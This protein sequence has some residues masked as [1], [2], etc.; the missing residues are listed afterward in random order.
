MKKSI[1]LALLTLAFCIA[2]SADKPA[3]AGRSC[4]AHMLS[5]NALTLG[6][7][8]AERT[9]KALDASGA[10]VAVLARAGQDLSQYKLRYSH[11]GLAYKTPAG[12]RVL[13]KLN[14]CGAGTAHLHLQG[15][16]EFF[17]DDPFRYEA[18]YMLLTPAAE[19]ALHQLLA[20][21]QRRSSMHTRP[22]SMVSYAWGTRYQQSN[23]WALETI[24]MAVDTR[25]GN[26]RDAQA[27]LRLAG[28]QPT[29]L[30]IPALTRLGARMT[31]TNVAFD[32]H[33]TARRFFKPTLC[34]AHPIIVG[35][36]R[37]NFSINVTQS[38]GRRIPRWSAVATRNI[39]S[40]SRQAGCVNLWPDVVSDNS[41]HARRHNCTQDR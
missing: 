16:G 28:Y 36:I 32:D 33:P 9:A 1:N 40:D 17:M 5:A 27:Y 2:F 18:A 10:Q 4:Q 6:M 8:L 37:V 29:T 41:H 13:H 21:T 31:Q 25:V 26:R 7:N 30:N 11:M 20:Q 12:W 22:Y 34:H 15:L 23:Q 39:R 35:V 14:T 3:H 38:F 24:A 19:Q